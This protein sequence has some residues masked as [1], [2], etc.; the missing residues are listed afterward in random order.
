MFIGAILFLL[1]FVMITPQSRAFLAALMIGLSGFM[2]AWAP[3]SYLLALLLV[4]A[5]FVG[6]YVIQTWPKHVE[7]EN[8]MSKYRRE[9]PV[10]E[11]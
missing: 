2:T 10:E 11:E 9:V 5:L 4:A 7:P 6:V 8:P 1:I 3:F